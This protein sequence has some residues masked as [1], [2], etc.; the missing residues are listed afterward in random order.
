[1]TT[2]EMMNKIA[3]VLADAKSAVLATV[4][5][6]GH[7]HARWMTPAVVPDMPGVLLAV[8]APDFKKI[9]QLDD[10]NR[11]EW[12]IQTK[13]LDQ[14]I[15]VRGGINIIDNPSLKAQV[16]ESVGRHLNIF[17]R[18]NPDKT[19]FVVLETVIEE[20]AWYQPMK[21]HREVVT[22]DVEER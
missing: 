5:K 10:N 19:D 16:M 15:N 6:E 2:Q 20:A 1:M 7:P 4:D 13:S 17:W 9:L 11:V 18:V 12:L 21:N 8:T 14:I 3:A 22:F